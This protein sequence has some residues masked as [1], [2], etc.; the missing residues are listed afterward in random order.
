M[1]R[2]GK[3]IHGAQYAVIT[4]SLAKLLERARST[5]TKIANQQA[6]TTPPELVLN[7]HCPECQFHSL[8][9]Q[10]A[11]EKDELSLLANMT[12]KEREK[13][14]RRGI[15]TVN[16]LSYTFQPRRRKSHKNSRAPKHESALKA[17]AIRKGLVHVVGSPR[18][19]VPESVVYLDVEGVPDRDFY[20]LIGLRCGGGDKIIQHSFWA[21]D[22]SDEPIIWAACMRVLKLIDNPCL[23][24]YGSYETQFLRRMKVRYVEGAGDEAFLDKLIS[25]SFNLLSLTYS[26]IYFPTYTNGLK[27]IA[28]YLGF[29]WSE[30][31]ASGLNT[32]V[33]RSDWEV[34]H[35]STLKQRI[36]KYNLEDCE[37]AKKVAEAIADICSKQPSMEPKAL[38]VNVNTLERDSPLRFG[39]LQYA[40]PDFKAINEAAY[41]DYLRA[42]VYVRSSDRLRRISRTGR[43]RQSAKVPPVNKSIQATTNRPKL[44]PNCNSKKLYRNGRFSHVLY[45][46]RFSPAGIR[47]W[48]VRH[49]FYQYHCRNCAH[50]YNELPRQEKFGQGLKAYVLYQIIE[51]RVS[52]H[53][54]ARSLTTL[55]GLQISKS[56][57]NR[58]KASAAIQYEATYRNILQRI[59]DGPLAHADETRVLINGESRYVWVFTNLEDVAYVYSESRDASTAR[60]VL[61]GFGGVLVTDFYSG[62]DSIDCAQQKCLIHLLRDINDD[63]GKE[64]FNKEM[65][66]LALAFAHV[67]R[68]IVETID[69][70]GLK[71][72]HLRKH[73]LAVARFY[74]VLS[75]RDYRT[76]V[77]AGYQKRFEKNRDKLFTFLEHDG[78][79]WNNNNAEHAIKAFARLRKD[80]SAKSTPKGVR[81]YL[82]LLSISET[83]NYKGIS[84][85]QFLRSGGVDIE[86]FGARP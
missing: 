78:V 76:E 44:C 35:D 81:E 27:D 49:C 48:V 14:N 30:R 6:N 4:V 11:V 55:F 39:S 42:K 41:W 18:F 45:D 75:K 52:Q 32:L 64:P 38:S 63:V 12:A 46:L 56:T 36:L 50:C 80:I 54:I 20:Y 19:V 29:E 82:V 13:Q 68:P 72:R 43:K 79:P 5:L 73:R 61:S 67:L 66:E 25:S 69:R 16:H 71:A 22:A 34:T 26:Q 17:L 33:W 65:E 24:H 57:I 86:E 10:V 77:A 53:A 84:F 15:F 9:R 8:C 28:R 1:P 51:L 37:A 7:R 3:I 62:Y 74:R 23:I 40:V 2:S 59:V 21:D 58:I 70:Y 83:C 85:L 31:D 47:R 60:E